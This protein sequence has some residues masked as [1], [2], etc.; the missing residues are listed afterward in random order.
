MTHRLKHLIICTVL[1]YTVSSDRLSGNCRAIG[2]FT[3]RFSIQM[4]SQSTYR[5][6]EYIEGAQTIECDLLNK[7]D[8]AAAF[9][10]FA[11]IATICC[12]ASRSGVSRDVRAVHH[13]AGYNTLQAL[14]KYGSS[15]NNGTAG[16]FVLLSAYCCGN[17]KLQFQYAKLKLEDVIRNS[18]V[19]PTAFFKSLESQLESARGG[20]PI[21]LFGD[22]SCSANPICEKDL[23]RFL[24][25]CALDA[26]KMDMANSTRAIGGPDVPPLTK[27]QQAELI[28]D[29]LDIVPEKRKVV[30]LPLAIFNTLIGLF[31]SGAALLKKINIFPELEEKLFD[32]A[33]LARIVQYYA[34]EPMIALGEGEVQ[35]TTRLR[36]HFQR[37]AARGGVLEEVDPMTTTAGVLSVF[38]NNTYYRRPS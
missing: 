6:S 37:L 12:P 9:K 20:S 29:T 11:P 30:Y 18:L 32:A 24:T 19:H 26:V 28:F 35:G 34:E 31:S 3:N 25:N 2:M 23:A 5:V 16:S 36:D 4:S 38:A 15:N 14:V 33:E 13:E 22:G 21:L 1:I 7:D 17:P 8:T 10:S 27:R